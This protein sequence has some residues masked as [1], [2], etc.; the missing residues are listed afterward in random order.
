MGESGEDARGRGILVDEEFEEVDGLVKNPDV[1]FVEGEVCVLDSFI[2]N[3][4]QA[5]VSGTGGAFVNGVRLV[6]VNWTVD[7][8]EG[9][10]IEMTGTLLV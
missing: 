10:A 9:G 4:G 5:L 1:A 2:I 8:P 7:D 6:F 3:E